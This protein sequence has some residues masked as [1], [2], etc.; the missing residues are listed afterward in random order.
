MLD[1]A[2]THASRQARSSTKR[3]LK[4]DSVDRDMCGKIHRRGRMHAREHGG[5]PP[6]RSRPRN[7]STTTVPVLPGAHD[8][9][10]N[11]LLAALSAPERERLLPHLELVEL[12]LGKVLY[13]PGTLL[14]HVYF[15]TDSIVSL[16]YVLEDG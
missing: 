3:R 11:H 9:A 4:E 6:L 10:Q 2:R 12:P 7:C 15:P 1:V 14:Y 8:P 13:E 16:L 5:T